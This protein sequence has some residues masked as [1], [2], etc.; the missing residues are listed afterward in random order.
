MTSLIILQKLSSLPKEAGIFYVRIPNFGQEF[1]FSITD[2]RFPYVVGDGKN[3]LGDLILTDPR[4]KIIPQTYFAR[5]KE[6]LDNIL[7][8][9]EKFLLSECGNH[10]QGAIFLNGQH[11]RSEKLL[12]TISEISRQIPDFYFGRFD[13]RYKDEESLKEGHFQIIEINGAGSEATHIW[14]ANTTLAEAYRT[15][16]EQWRL[17]FEIGYQISLSQNFQ[18]NIDLKLFLKESFKVY[19]RKET[20]SV[21]S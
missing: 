9:D 20:L 2:K 7:N 15:L 13:V 21:S 11:L 16:F 17:L 6:N 1:I 8:L 19:F 4:A 5:H 12:S 18:S 3:K 14:D 10:C